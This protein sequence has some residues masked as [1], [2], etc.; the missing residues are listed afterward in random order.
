MVL[1]TSMKFNEAQKRP[2]S[3]LV[4]VSQRANALRQVRECYVMA[5]QAAL[6][7]FAVGLDPCPQLYAGSPFS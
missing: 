4:R 1:V 5:G 3:A 6:L 2:D 7:L